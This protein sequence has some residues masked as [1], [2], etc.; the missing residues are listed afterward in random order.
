MPASRVLIRAFVGTA[1]AFTGV[2]ARHPT[3]DAR[4]LF[5]V[6][7]DLLAPHY[8]LDRPTPHRLV[9]DTTPVTKMG[10]LVSRPNL[11][12]TDFSM[13]QP[14]PLT[15]V[16]RLGHTIG[17]S[18]RMVRESVVARDRGGLFSWTV[19]LLLEI[20]SSIFAL[21]KDIIDV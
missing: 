20:G 5:R 8:A 15:R 10:N 4:R 19:S 13:V 6:P 12:A 2:R 16:L 11:C 1:S 3:M 14:M 9:L 7:Q 17:M 21:A 18:T